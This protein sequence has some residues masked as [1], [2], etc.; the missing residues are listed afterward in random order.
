MDTVVKLKRHLLKSNANLSDHQTQLIFQALANI[1]FDAPSTTAPLSGYIA[2]DEISY[3]WDQRTHKL[4]QFLITLFNSNDIDKNTMLELVDSLIAFVTSR[5]YTVIGR[6]EKSAWLGFSLVRYSKPFAAFESTL[7]KFSTSLS[8][9]NLQASIETP[10][11]IGLLAFSQGMAKILKQLS[12]EP[13]KSGLLLLSFSNFLVAQAKPSDQIVANYPFNANTLD[14]S[15]YSTS[16]ALVFGARFV[17]DRFNEPNSALY[18]NG[19]AFVR[20]PATPFP[21]ASRTVEVWVKPDENGG[22]A[23]FGYGGGGNNKGASFNLNINDKCTSTNFEIE[24]FN[25]QN[26]LIY[27]SQNMTIPA[28]VWTLLTVTTSN[29]EGTNIYFNGTLAASASTSI[30]NTFTQGNLFAI[31]AAAGENGEVPDTVCENKFKG[32]IDDLK[33]YNKDLTV[34]EVLTSY[35]AAIIK[36]G[37]SNF[38]KYIA[39]PVLFAARY[40]GNHPYGSFVGLSGFFGT[41]ALQYI[42]AKKE[43]EA[44]AGN[45]RPAPQSNKRGWIC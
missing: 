6:Y 25:S 34:G 41:L 39:S 43:N 30:D 16:P 5:D 14:E 29:A 31:G 32:I 2:Q 33:V 21:R 37:P 36:P 44:V 20:G 12:N 13:I 28:N 42:K 4:N 11:V 15:G 7:K 1:L 26:R 3:I 35:K 18:F 38:W 9:S 27:T 19:K 23:I 17:T 8:E 40:P 45:Y 22:G 10:V 24:T